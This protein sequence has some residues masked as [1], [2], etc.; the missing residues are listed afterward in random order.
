MDVPR[1][2]DPV[3]EQLSI[4]VASCVRL[5][6][7][8][9]GYGEIVRIRTTTGTPLI[10]KRVVPPAPDAD[11]PLGWK[12]ARG[13]ARK[14]RSYEVEVAFYQRFAPRCGRGCPV[15]RLLLAETSPQGR[16]LVLEDL[17]AAGF[18]GRHGYDA[19][20]E[21]G[22]LAA[23]LEWLA[24]FHATFLGVAPE[25]LWEE[26]TYWHLDTR[27]DELAAMAHG[28]LRDAAGRLDAALR[29]ARHRTLVHGDAKLPNFCF[30]PS[31]VAAVDFQYV[32]GGVGVRDV[33]YL[34]GGARRE[35]A[36]SREAERWHDHYF[37]ALRAALDDAGHPHG[38]AVEAE[39]RALLPIAW[40]D[41]ERFLAGWAPDHWKRS[42]YAEAQVEAALSMVGPARW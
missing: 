34:V 31:G 9:S 41:F 28:P 26:G 17:D 29:G 18:A 24:R 14:L 1:W 12:G 20:I 21:D 10:A 5:Q 30:G 32:G 13:H 33:A 11:H 22:E 8:W 27:P 19:A 15:A 39:W 35:P 40:A 25:A 6:S 38:D 7:L 2:I 37:G 23:C 16:V 36:L 4:A 3:A 42:R